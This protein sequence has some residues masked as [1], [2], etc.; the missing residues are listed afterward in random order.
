M[1]FLSREIRHLTVTPRGAGRKTNS[2]RLAT[3]ISALSAV[4]DPGVTASWGGT[5]TGSELVIF[6]LGLGFYSLS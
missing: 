6:S 4:G 5:N 1:P 3:S 2:S